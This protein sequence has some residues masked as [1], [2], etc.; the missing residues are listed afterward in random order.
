MTRWQEATVQSFSDEK[1]QSITGQIFVGL[2]V[3]VAY[4]LGLFKLI[5]EKSLSVQE[6][7]SLLGVHERAVQAMISC[8]GAL[9]LV[10]HRDNGYGLSHLGK[11][12]LDANSPGYYG[13]VLDLLIK[14]SSIMSY[15][16]IKLVLLSN[17]ACLNKEGSLFTHSD[18][19]SSTEQ[20][21]DALH[22]KAFQPAFHWSK[23]TDL[24][25]HKRMVDIGGGSG[26]HTIAA[27]LHHPLLEGVVCDRSS[28]LPFT[29]KYIA[30]F[31]LGDRIS[32][33]PL[34]IWADA[35]PD[36]DIHFFGDIF[37]DWEPEDCLFLARKSFQ[38]LPSN[39]K[40]I[41]HEMLFNSDKTGPFLTA[42]YNMK[43]M[44][45]TKGQQ[46]ST[47]EIRDIL[48]QAGFKNIELRQSLG[49]WS[50]IIGQKE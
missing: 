26:I 7:S 30:Q 29:R 41:L 11:T 9:M 25:Q 45:W 15:E 6:L 13:K 36:G 49:N 47:V 2:A 20:F 35:F 24:R 17:R 42:A 38:C 19:L 12:Y 23:V 27:C 14:E 40:I 32:T 28:V 43:M 10:Q 50:L 21:V 8:A 3:L 4:E 44:A 22:H 31:S 16:N 37:H 5:W 34:D 33:L 1:L 18:H 39:G 48:C 46:F